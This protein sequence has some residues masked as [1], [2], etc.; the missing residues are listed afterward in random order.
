MKGARGEPNVTH[1]DWHQSLRSLQRG[2]S[3]VG[4]EQARPVAQN[5]RAERGRAAG[6]AT[7]AAPATATGT[8]DFGFVAVKRSPS[9]AACHMPL[10][11]RIQP[12]S[13]GP[14]AQGRLYRARRSRPAA[15]RRARAR[16]AAAP[17]HILPRARGRR[18]ASPGRAGAP[19]PRACHRCRT[20]RHARPHTAAAA[21][22]DHVA[23]LRAQAPWE[24]AARP[25]PQPR[26]MSAVVS[27][28]GGSAAAGDADGDVSGVEP[29]GGGGGG[30]RKRPAEG[31]LLME[32]RP[33]LK[34]MVPSHG[35]TGPRPCQRTPCC[36]RSL[37]FLPGVP[38][39][40]A[41]ERLPLARGSPHLRP[42]E[43][44]PPAVWGA[45]GHAAEVQVSL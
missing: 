9:A 33:E 14:A 23:H 15:R 36:P 6:G 44:E 13:G 25:T 3:N 20:L 2:A 16:Q 37:P 27:V 22:N 39:L 45:A 10:S 21:S 28:G 5:G 34:V 8:E 35:R 7:R 41:A 42:A 17:T 26:V 19:S 38:A 29:P 12:R 32:D 4:L 11:S 18:P 40:T 24:A 31:G 30:A 1:H 43:E